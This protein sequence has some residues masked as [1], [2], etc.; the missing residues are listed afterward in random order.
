MDPAAGPPDPV[1]ERATAPTEVSLRRRLLPAGLMALLLGVGGVGALV[2][3]GSPHEAATLAEAWPVLARQGGAALAGLEPLSPAEL[4]SAQP[5]SRET[6]SLVAPRGV[7]G[8]ARPRIR[9]GGVPP[10]E[11]VLLELRSAEGEVRWRRGA[12]GGMLDWPRELPLEQPGAYELVLAAGGQSTSA[13]F[14]LAR[15]EARA[16]L[17]SVLEAVRTHVPARLQALAGAHACAR[18]GWWL[19]AEA[20]AQEALKADARDADALAL[21]RWVHAQLGEAAT[22]AGYAR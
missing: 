17:Q 22:W 3:C 14:E 4:A 6:L 12:V 20:R 1:P 5:P 18:L 8:D 10:T 11:T 19:A 21:L 2:R 9:W 15:P 16:R 7:V 13:R